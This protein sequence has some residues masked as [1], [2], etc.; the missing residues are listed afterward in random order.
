MKLLHIVATPRGDGSRTLKVA[1][2]FFEGLEQN[3]PDCKVDTLDVT[4]EKLPPMTVEA[5]N[6]KYV[7]LGGKDLTD[8]L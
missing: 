3:A 8:D 1:E 5:V 7:L 4:K 2:A 6:G